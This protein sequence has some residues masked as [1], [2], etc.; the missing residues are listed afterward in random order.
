[1]KPVYTFTIVPTLPPALQPLREIAYNL[2]WAWDRETIE[3]FRRLDRDLWETTY[4]NPVRMLGSISQSQLE[5]MAADESFIAHMKRVY[6]SL[7][8]YMTATTWYEKAFGKDSKPYVAYFSAEFGITDCVPIYSGGLGVLAGDH[9]KSASDLGLPLVG[10]GLLYQ[11]GYFRQYLNSDGWQQEE[12]PDNDFYNMP[13]QLERHEDGSVKTVTVEYPTGPVVARIW[14]A[15]IGRV[16][17]FLLDTNTQVNARAE[18][19]DIT[20]QL[21]VADPEVRIRQQIMLGIGGV[22]ALKSL[23]IHP[24]VYH[25]N[26]GYSAFLAL[27]RICQLVSEHGLSLN[28]AKEAVLATDIFTTH[29]PEPAGIDVF[30]AQFVEKYIGDH[31]SRLGVSLNDVL[32]LGR[33]N[34]VNASDGFSMAI[35]ALRL[36]SHSNAVSE[37]HGGVSR[38]MWKDIWP[39]VPEDEVPI[40]SISNGVHVRSWVSNDME[41]LFDRYLGPWWAE[42][43]TDLRVWKQIKKI[44]DDELWRTHERRRERLVAFARRRLQQQLERRGA[45]SSEVEQAIESLNPEALTIGFARR[46]TTY[47]RAALILRNTERLAKILCNRDMP[48]QIIYAG[49]A[50]PQD[51]AGKELIREIIH[52]ARQENLRRHIVFIEDHDMNI[53]R[54]LIQGSDLWLST[55]RRLREASGT[56]G[57]KAAINGVINMSILDGW[58][59]EA[60]KTE[61]GWAIG[62]EEL[63]EDEEYQ[64]EVESNAIYDILE[65]EVVPLF[66][67]R[68]ND[69]L[70]RGWIAM[71]K[72]TMSTICP[73]YNTDRMVHEYTM[74]F[75][76]PCVEQW[77]TLT[78]DDFARAKELAAWKSHLREQWS[79]IRI[80]SVKMDEVSEVKVGDQITVR[81]Q[82][83]LGAITPSDVAVEIYQGPVDPH[84][85]EITKA[86][87]IQMNCMASH[88]NGDYTFEGA[89]PCRSSGMFGYSVRILPKRENVKALYEQ[90]L[91]LWAS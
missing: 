64:D 40:D 45:S 78:A 6:D 37:L 23:G 47:K 48:V 38:K 27:E 72:A 60:Y 3:L 18:D 4:H 66:Y 24:V 71:M 10:V 8:E 5:A 33:Q 55:P 11:K 89:I 46:F 9:L 39:G 49:K 52:T 13:V 57:M 84:R 35:L 54:Y 16:A 30:P 21:Y 25:M 73:I 76:H 69:G 12:Y 41:G 53:A 83:H 20:D 15:Q 82:V 91:I 61:I 62:R 32:A 2:L 36:S 1:M 88:G 44:P 75:Y 28:E 50:H 58:W 79:S 26:E 42:D 59:H 19:R 22:R 14:R 80:D 31:C 56:S 43:P 34:P 74:R 70:P 63:Y 87:T 29:T 7:K 81:T 85:G 90:G 86:E 51:M 68:G 17:L 67:D 77:Q 65:K